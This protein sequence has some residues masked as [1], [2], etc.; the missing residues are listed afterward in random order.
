MRTILGYLA[1]GGLAYWL[2]NEYQRS[3]KNGAKLKR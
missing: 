3:K 2:Y 1:I